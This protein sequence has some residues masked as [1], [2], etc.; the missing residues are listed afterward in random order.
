MGMTTEYS[1]S[2]VLV[3]SLTSFFIRPQFSWSW[4][5]YMEMTAGSCIEGNLPF[6]VAIS[7]WRQWRLS[8]ETTLI[9]A[10]KEYCSPTG[11]LLCE[12]INNFKLRWH[13]VT[14]QR[15]L[16][17]N[18]DY[19]V[20]QTMATQD[21]YKKR[22]LHGWGGDFL[23]NKTKVFWRQWQLSMSRTTSVGTE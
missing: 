2:T 20:L 5:Q 15:G 1:K 19:S 14:E 13:P 4:W 7:S 11:Q 12:N 8:L 22:W 18:S 3:R 23:L 17:H 21:G 9:V 16:V 10:L 6:L